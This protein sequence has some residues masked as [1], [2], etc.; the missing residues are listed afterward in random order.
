MA[1]NPLSMYVFYTT[2]HC[3]AIVKFLYT[4]MLIMLQLLQTLTHV[5]I[6]FTTK[7]QSGKLYNSYR[8]GGQ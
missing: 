7:D 3:Y 6:C 8:T 1:H 4:V 5:Q 2:L